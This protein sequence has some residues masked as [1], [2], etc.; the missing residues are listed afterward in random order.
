MLA[1]ANSRCIHS[2]APV[3][4]LMIFASSSHLAFYCIV[5]Q[6]TW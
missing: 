4:H 5:D 6:F 3:H 1:A 2:Q